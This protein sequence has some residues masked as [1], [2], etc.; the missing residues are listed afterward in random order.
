MPPS[1][2]AGA[3]GRRAGPEAPHPLATPLQFVKGVG[4]PRAKLLADLGLHTVEDALY[5]LPTRR[6]AA[7][8]RRSGASSP[9]T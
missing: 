6:T 9:T 5:Y 8:S 4:P 7:S 2:P 3:A 1:K